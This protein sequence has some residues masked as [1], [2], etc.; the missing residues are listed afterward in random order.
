MR[1]FECK[2]LDWPAQQPLRAGQD[3]GEHRLAQGSRSR[4]ARAIIAPGVH[5]VASLQSKLRTAQVVHQ[6]FK[7]Q[8]LCQRL[9]ER[10]AGQQKDAVD[11]VSRGLDALPQAPTECGASVLAGA[12]QQIEV[13]RHRHVRIGCCTSILRNAFSARQFNERVCIRRDDAARE[14]VWRDRTSGWRHCGM[15]KGVRGSTFGSIQAR[16]AARA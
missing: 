11:A 7:A 14:A 16:R 15:A 12:R 5:R 8:H 1:E 10:R 2:A 3:A 4:V 13:L 6:G 9:A